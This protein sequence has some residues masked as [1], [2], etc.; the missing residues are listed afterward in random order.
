VKIY[1]RDHKIGDDVTRANWQQSAERRRSDGRFPSWR[2]ALETE[3]VFGPDLLGNARN[4]EM[5][6]VDEPELEGDQNI[7]FLHCPQQTEREKWFAQFKEEPNAL[8]G[9][10]VLIS[11]EGRIGQGQIPAGLKRAFG[12]WWKPIDF[13][14]AARP[15]VLQFIES[16]KAGKPRFELL[17]PPDKSESPDLLPALAVLCQGYLLAMNPK[18]NLP[19][20][21]R[22]ELQQEVQT[23]GWWKQPFREFT[24]AQMFSA[25]LESEW[26]QEVP[27][28]VEGLVVAI[29]RGSTISGATVEEAARALSGRLG[30]SI[31][32]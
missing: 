1:L 19:N 21:N 16:V 5:R 30:Y 15:E 25:E 18:S 23:P 27:S 20:V 13:E 3:K 31:A 12:C 7:V 8:K 9:Y 26:G 32:A 11:T 17:Q 24:N 28:S 10:L 22:G 6:R 4:H 2:S 14:E 29:F